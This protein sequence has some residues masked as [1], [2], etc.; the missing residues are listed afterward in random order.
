MY[1]SRTLTGATV[2]AAERRVLKLMG[3]DFRVVEDV[4]ALVAR[5]TP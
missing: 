1:L 2:L 3:S 5:L 4:G